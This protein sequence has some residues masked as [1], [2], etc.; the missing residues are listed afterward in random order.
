MS[1]LLS[2][3]SRRQREDAQIESIWSTPFDAILLGG[4]GDDL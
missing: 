4:D 3:A 1:D 2:A